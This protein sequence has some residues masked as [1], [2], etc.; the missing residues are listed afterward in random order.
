MPSAASTRK[1]LLSAG[2]RKSPRGLRQLCRARFS[3]VALLRRTVTAAIDATNAATGR[4]WRTVQR[5]RWRAAASHHCGDF[6]V[7]EVLTWCGCGL[8]GLHTHPLC[9]L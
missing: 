8:V 7:A 2:R 5:R 9:T 1:T 6:G 3:V 4:R